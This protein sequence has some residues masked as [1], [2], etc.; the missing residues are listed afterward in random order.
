M[1]QKYK[2]RKYIPSG[3]CGAHTSGWVRSLGRENGIRDVGACRDGS[4]EL[5]DCDVVVDGVF[6]IAWVDDDLGDFD[7]GSA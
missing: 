7:E 2:G 4:G 1:N 6:V 5:P 3:N